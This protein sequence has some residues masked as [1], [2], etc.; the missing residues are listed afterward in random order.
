[1]I[2]DVRQN[3]PGSFEAL[4]AVNLCP[5]SHSAPALHPCGGSE[6]KEAG[7]KREGRTLCHLPYPCCPRSRS[8]PRSLRR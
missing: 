6:R 2:E 3:E 7:R 1:M 4:M 5:N 8:L